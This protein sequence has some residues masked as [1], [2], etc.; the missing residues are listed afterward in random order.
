[1]DIRDLQDRDDSVCIL[2]HIMVWG[3]AFQ[4]S[5]K[6]VFVVILWTRTGENLEKKGHM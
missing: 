3:N 2:L 1:M 5:L 6:R 4:I